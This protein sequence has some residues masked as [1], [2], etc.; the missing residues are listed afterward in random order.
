MLKS[1]LE[2]LAQ[3]QTY[4][5]SVTESDYTAILAPKFI[6]SAGA[7][8]RHII[9][10]Y[11][12]IISGFENK[13]IDY[14]VRARGGEIES[15]PHL[16]VAKLNYIAQWLERL[17]EEDLALMVSLS[18]EVSFSDKNIQIVQTSIARELIFAGSHAV[19]HFAMIAQ[20][21]LS[22]NKIL[23][24]AFGLAPATATFLRHQPVNH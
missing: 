14:D 23:P 17:S 4:L 8:I 3:A 1:Q 16:A 15:L 6:G 10:H 21:T 2:I 24:P 12:A 13:L 18:T 11:L 9:D 5:I 20:I 7:H 22:Q 19:H